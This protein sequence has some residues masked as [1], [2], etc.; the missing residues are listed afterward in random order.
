M[1]DTAQLATDIA[2]T[3]KLLNQLR[4]QLAQAQAETQGLIWEEISDR[5]LILN[6]PQ[7]RN[8]WSDLTYLG[9][10]TKAAAEKC[11]KALVKTQAATAIEGARPAKRV[12]AYKWELKIH[13]LHP[14][15][16]EAIVR[17]QAAADAA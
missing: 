1:R 5:I 9:F 10:R 15:A 16:L 7:R 3:E 13:D 2:T 8:G 17:K 12:K 4:Q 11:L 6:D 14:Q